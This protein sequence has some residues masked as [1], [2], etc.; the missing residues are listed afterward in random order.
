ME[1]P[2]LQE[3]VELIIGRPLYSHEKLV[4]DTYS[5]IPKDAVIRIGRD[6]RMHLYKKE[7]DYGH[8]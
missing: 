4:L 5:K 2:T 6:G 8:R 7:D 3:Y 1:F